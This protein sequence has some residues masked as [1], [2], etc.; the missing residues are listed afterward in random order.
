MQQILY[1]HQYGVAQTPWQAAVASKSMQ[2]ISYGRQ[3][4]LL[5]I[6]GKQHW[7]HVACC[8]SHMG[9]MMV[10]SKISGKQRRH[11]VA[12]RESVCASAWSAQNQAGLSKAACLVHPCKAY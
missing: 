5:K 1:G 2:Q 4:G 10:C 6:G 3:Y 8:R 11:H 9:I 7:H 12:G